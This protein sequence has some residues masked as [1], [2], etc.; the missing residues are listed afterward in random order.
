[1]W[2]ILGAV[3]SGIGNYFAAESQ[4]EA[5]EKAAQRQQQAINQGLQFQQQALNNGLGFQQGQYGNALGFQQQQQALGNS[6]VGQTQGATQGALNPYAQGGQAA[7]GG[8]AEFGQAGLGAYQNS[9]Q[10]QQ[11]LLGLNGADAQAAAIA[12]IQGGPQFDALKRAGENAILQNASATGGLRGGNVQGALAQFSPQILS[13]LINQQYAQLGGLGSLGA[14]GMQ[15]YGSL[16]QI[17]LGG[18]TSQASGGLDALRAQLGLIGQTSSNAASLSNQLSGAGAGLYDTFAKS[19]ADLLGQGGANAAMQA[20]AQG[21]TDAR[22]WQ[23]LG[24]IPNQALMF[25]QLT[26]G[27]GFGG[28]TPPAPAQTN[29]WGNLTNALS[30][31]Q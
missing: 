23:A 3:A 30:R 1:M 17:G 24:G 28:S 14:Q 12:A 26:G 6:L 11:G 13:Q 21:N 9:I 31:G 19:T 2:E 4:A 18:A 27:Q 5:A 16:G 7:L 22:Q 15:A 25:G 10:G 8:L 20:M 29:W